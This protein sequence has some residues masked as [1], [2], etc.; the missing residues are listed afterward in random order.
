MSCKWMKL[1][2]RL[3]VLFLL[4]WALYDH[5]SFAE[6]IGPV[7]VKLIL[8]GKSLFESVQLGLATM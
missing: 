6:F 5:E 8:A 1:I 7:I 3:T 2:Y 4:C